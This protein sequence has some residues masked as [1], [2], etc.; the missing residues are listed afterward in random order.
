MKKGI[1]IVCVIA[2]ALAVFLFAGNEGGKVME[3]KVTLKTFKDITTQQLENIA[4]K[5]IYFGHQSVGSNMMKGLQE[6]TEAHD[7]LKLN[8]VETDTAEGI[9]G[10][11]FAHARIGKNKKPNSKVDDFVRQLESGLGNKVDIAFCKF[12][13]ADIL[14]ETDVNATFQYYKK[15][16]KGL[17]EKFPNVAF[18]HCTVPYYRRT[19]GMKGI[20]KGMMGKDK[21]VKRNLFN[22][23]ME[24]EYK[25]EEIFDLGKFES[26]YPDGGREKSGKET[27]AL[28]AQYTKDGGHLNKKGREVIALQLIDFLG[29]K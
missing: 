20:L 29:S 28:V 1:I 12:C 16:M 18:I 9:E 17:K 13:Y 21:N 27:Y 25:S 2:A 23:L 6:L 3:E 7:T 5:R 19:T 4:G 22:R 24:K 14:P 11:F 8:I 26:T 10:A 15:A